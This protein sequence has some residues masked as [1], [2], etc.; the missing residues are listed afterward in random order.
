MDEDSH[1]SH[2]KRPYPVVNDAPPAPTPKRPRV[3]HTAALDIPEVYSDAVRKKVN[4]PAHAYTYPLYL[5]Q[6]LIKFA[7]IKRVSDGPG[8]RPLQREKNEM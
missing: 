5:G 8:V 2:H 4:L 1:H 3:T 7:A 6:M